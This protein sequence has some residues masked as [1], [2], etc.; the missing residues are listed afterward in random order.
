MRRV[1][2][3]DMMEV[4]SK[5]HRSQQASARSLA[6]LP[7]LTH[8]GMLGYHRL[9]D[10][11]QGAALLVRQADDGLLD[12]VRVGRLSGLGRNLLRRGRHR[13]CVEKR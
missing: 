9:L 4:C 11:R 6:M 2:Q 10:G 8:L 5:A 12:H 1:V 3:H 7:C 13:A